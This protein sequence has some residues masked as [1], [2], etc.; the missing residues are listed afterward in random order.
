MNAYYVL[1]KFAKLW[2]LH[3]VDALHREG[4]KPVE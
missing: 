3:S 1:L 2:E 4:T